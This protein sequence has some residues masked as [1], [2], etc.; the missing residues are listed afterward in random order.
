MGPSLLTLI[1]ADEMNKALYPAF[2]HLTKCMGVSSLTSDVLYLKLSAALQSYYL[3]HYNSSLA[4]HYWGVSRSY[5]TP[6]S[7]STMSVS[8]ESLTPSSHSSS[9][10]LMKVL[11]VLG[12]VETILGPF[13][14]QKLRN[15]HN[16]QYHGDE[17][18][19]IKDI[20][21]TVYPYVNLG[22]TLTNTLIKLGYFL[23]F[24]EKFSISNSLL[25]ISYQSSSPP[26]NHSKLGTLRS[27]IELLFPIS[28]FYV[29]FIKQWSSIEGVSPYEATIKPP[30]PYKKSGK[31]PACSSGGAPDLC[32]ICGERLRIPTAMPTTGVVYCYVCIFTHVQSSGSCPVSHLHVGTADLIKLNIR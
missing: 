2:L 8:C 29:Q 3:Y 24:T 19:K 15:I 9:G 16:D 10:Q 11:K 27:V 17:M 6:S 22:V 18:S 7:K 26:L 30:P 20:L 4:E 32:P 21:A 12:C 23:R 1:S 31:P 28:M 14:N 5:L 13:L 25:N